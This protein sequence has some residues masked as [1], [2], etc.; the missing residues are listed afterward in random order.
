M[1]LLPEPALERVVEKL[2]PRR[3]RALLEAAE[4]LSAAWG[5]TAP[6]GHPALTGRRAF[7]SFLLEV[8]ARRP[9]RAGLG[10][11]AHRGVLRARGPALPGGCV[12]AC[13]SRRE[14]VRERRPAGGRGRSCAPAAALRHGR[15]RLL[16]LWK[17]PARK[18]REN[19]PPVRQA[20]AGD[21]AEPLYV[22][23]AGLVLAGAFLPHLFKMLDLLGEDAAGKV[24][25]RDVETASR[26]VHLLQYLIHGCT[27]SPEPA[28]ALNKI[29][30]GLPLESPVALEIAP[31]EW[32]REVCDTLLRSLLANWTI[33]QNTSV[34][35]LQET[36][37][38]RE[39]RLE[40]T[41]EGWKLRV[42]RKTVDVL[43]DEVPW[44]L[45]MIFHRWMPQPLQV[46]W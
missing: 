8:L 6:P 37:L 11:A 41:S 21:E 40:R 16:A 30:C 29:L 23:N 10:G 19:R 28:L 25:L 18:R 27:A 44:S 31:T 36:F 35:G 13:H 33:V 38:Q 5:E 39:G 7:W 3:H 34:A 46:A 22:D 42:Q 26:A 20:K 1:K 15:P 9:G 4:V 43:V 12:R 2:A 45:S 32:E 17:P 24:R 14:A